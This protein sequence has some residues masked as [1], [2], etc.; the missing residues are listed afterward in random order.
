MDKV[1]TK[2][3]IK[4]GLRLFI[5]VSSI[6]FVVPTKDLIKKGLRLFSYTS[7]VSI[8]SVPTKDLIKKGLRPKDSC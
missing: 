8:V 6:W 1:P 2:D 5:V 3:L 4:K 7:Y